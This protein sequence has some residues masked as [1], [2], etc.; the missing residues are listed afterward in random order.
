MA[1]KL[2]VLVALSLL[3]FAGDAHG[4]IPYCGPADST[5]PEPAP[6]TYAPEPAA[7]TTPV[8]PTPSSY[9]P[10][11]PAPT[12]PTTDGH[13]HRPAR[14]CPVDALQLQ[15][16]ASILDGLVKVSLPEERERCCRLLDG[17][18]DIDAAACLCTVL[19][20]NVLGIP[21]RVPINIS[22]SLNRCGRR[23]CPP[24]LTCPRY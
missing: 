24:G 20:A 9:A 22:L 18:V 8:A 1:A 10:Q 11:P 16:C 14:R 17:L 12:V 5:P 19:K 6:S 7:P 4:C 3:L 2:G 21:L 13:G 23:D 15:V